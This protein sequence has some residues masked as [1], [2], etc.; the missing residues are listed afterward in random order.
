M[1]GGACFTHTHTHA[2]ILIH[3]HVHTHTLTHSHTH[4]C[5][6]AHTHTHGSEP[7]RASGEHRFSFEALVSHVRLHSHSGECAGVN[8]VLDSGLLVGRD[9]ASSAARAQPPAA[10]RPVVRGECLT[11]ARR[12][13]GNRKMRTKRT[14]ALL[15]RHTPLVKRTGPGGTASRAHGCSTQPCENQGEGCWEAWAFCKL[16]R[17]AL[18][19]RIGGRPP[20]RG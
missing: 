14:R 15:P 4:T 18:T 9:Q 19:P 20:P 13:A 2:H 16:P 17:D 10:F 3:S 5:T 1:L 11:L 8:G 7:L 6:H 12:V